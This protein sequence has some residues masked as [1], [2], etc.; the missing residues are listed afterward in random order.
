MSICTRLSDPAEWER[1]Y[2]Y[3]E[4]N[5]HLT[6]E[7]AADLRAF[8]DAREYEPVVSRILSGGSFSVPE[9]KLIRKMHSDKK[10]AVYLFPR[11]ENYVLKLL[12]FLLLRSYDHLFTEDLYSFRVSQGAGRALSRILHAPG[13][14][15]MYTYKVDIH[16]YFNSVNVDQILEML[17]EILQDDPLLFH[18]FTQILNDPRVLDQGEIK[19]EQKGVMAGTPF[20]VFLANLYLLPLDREMKLQGFLYARYSDDIML[21]APTAERREEGVRI[22]LDALYARDLSVNTEKEVRTAPGE[23][24]T[25]LGISYTDGIIDVSP[26]STDKLKARIRRKARAIKRWQVRKQASNEQ[27]VK[28]LIRSMN[29][30]YF[31]ADSSHELTWTRWY[32]PLITTDRTLHE[33]DLYLQ[34]WI[35]YLAA[36][37]HRQKN[38]E[39]R[40]EEMKALGYQSLV[41]AWYEKDSEASL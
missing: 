41:H 1:Y 7:E 17:S 5:R 28:A 19:E 36:G 40:Y 3:K 22:I 30:K 18:V 37:R 34:Y 9:K 23:M 15:D 24:W 11:E 31:S 25:F 10:R 35:R 13:L 38:Y 29:R 14:H 32:F 16:D 33:L 26:V 4:E 20:A 21:F 8:I 12:T 2:L 27:A 39:F 6:R